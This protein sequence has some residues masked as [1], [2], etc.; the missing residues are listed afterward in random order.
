L[1]PTLASVIS[2]NEKPRFL[3]KRELADRRRVTPRTIERWM[4]DKTCRQ[5]LD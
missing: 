4:R 3:T 5:L 2:V 1:F